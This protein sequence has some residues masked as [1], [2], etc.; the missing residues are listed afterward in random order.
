MTVIS[1]AGW[2]WRSRAGPAAALA[3]ALALTAF[4]VFLVQR[5]AGGGVAACVAATAMTLP[6]AFAQRAPLWSAAVLAPAAAANELFFGHLIRC[7]AALP[8]A[9]FVAYVAG[10]SCAGR[11]RALTLAL[12][13]ACV[14]IQCVYDPQLGSA[15]SPLMAAVSGMFFGAGLL[16]RRRS[17]MVAQLRRSTDQLRAQ[18][19]RTARLAV[20]AEQARITADIRGTLRAG[21]DEIGALAQ[22]TRDSGADPGASFAAIESAGRSV[23]DSM[24]HVVGTLREAPTDPEPGLAELAA[25]LGSATT[26]DARLSVTGP[27]RPLPASIELAGYRIVEQL[28]TVL[29]DDP[30]SRVEVRVRFAAD[31]LELRIAGPPAADDEVRRVRSVVQARLALYGGTVDI[32]DAAGRRAA[33]IRLPLVTSHV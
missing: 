9:F 27:A 5:Q 12:V 2:T 11:R 17:A 30:A 22:A 14:L 23:L 15:V 32:D 18:R 16:V 28:L 33:R 19:E 13:L 24:R 29:R 20:A 10:R 6:V 3:S 31:C 21:I 26:A 7:G 8:A 25:L 4:I 1:E